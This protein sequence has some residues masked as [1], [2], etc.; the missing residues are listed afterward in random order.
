MTIE[1]YDK[2]CISQFFAFFVTK[3]SSLG[4]SPRRL[5]CRTS[6]QGTHIACSTLHPK[7]QTPALLISQP[8]ESSNQ[9]LQRLISRIIGNTKRRNTFIWAP[10]SDNA[11]LFPM[12]LSNIKTFKIEWKYDLWSCAWRNSISIK[13]RAWQYLMTFPSTH[14]QPFIFFFSSEEKGISYSS[15]VFSKKSSVF[16]WVNLSKPQNH[17][18]TRKKVLKAAVWFRHPN[19]LL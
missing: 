17:T 8:L 13:N 19:P 12:S 3:H 2:G 16:W 6:S 11:R 9:C 10:L 14:L 7:P 15:G 1:S 18:V 4:L 5:P